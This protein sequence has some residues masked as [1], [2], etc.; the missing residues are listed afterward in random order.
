VPP[1]TL[2][3]ADARREALVAAAIPLFAAKGFHATSTAEVAKAAGISHAYV[4]RLFPSKVDLFVAVVDEASQRMLRHFSAVI[5]D[6]EPGQDPLEAAGKAYGDFVRTDREVLLVQLGAQV[7]AGAEPAVA[8]ASRRCF[9]ALFAM[10]TEVSEAPVAEIQ[11]WFAHGMLINTMAAIG[12]DG[13]H[14]P[15]ARALTSWHDE[16]C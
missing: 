3:T 16:S 14:E 7:V 11:T 15:W 6:R 12:A 5:A 10:V 4:F 9:A 13:V 2:S 1:R 8:A